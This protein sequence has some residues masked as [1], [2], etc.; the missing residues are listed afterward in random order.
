MNLRQ[1]IISTIQRELEPL[2][3][4]NAL[5]EAGSA[6]FDR[7]DQYSDIDLQIDVADDCVEQTFAA[8]E[9]ALRSV[10]PITDK[11]RIPEPTWHGHSQCFY[12]LRDAG[13]Y[14]QI[15]CAIIKNSSADKF[16][17]SE[18]HGDPL[19][20]FDK[21][22]VVQSPP[23][24]WDAHNALLRERVAFLT[25][26]F[27]RMQV[28]VRKE[29]LRRHPIDALGF[30]RPMTLNP[31]IELLRI[32]HDPARYNWGLRYLHRH[33]S[34]SDQAR[35]ADLLYLQDLDELEE[36]HNSAQKWFWRLAEELKQI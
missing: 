21:A 23:F 2:D 33:L 9:T 3:F 26:R 35:L 22:E 25:E 6:A 16:L 7:L 30:F 32:K 11:F 19:V 5:W 28:Y 27:A 17:Q 4:V 29:I 36:K 10:S 14:L 1:Q 12:K 13:D 20:I 34:L 24:D 8:V 18:L 31:L 15:D